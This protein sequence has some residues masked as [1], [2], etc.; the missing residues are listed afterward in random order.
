[1]NQN[2]L[3]RTSA[4]SLSLLFAIAI[5]ACDDHYSTQ[6][7][8]A[9]CEDLTS[10]NPATNPPE[11]FLDCVACHESCGIDCQQRGSSPEDYVCPSEL[12]EAAGGG[13]EGGAGG[14][15]E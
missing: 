12:D 11:T 15:A 4:A 8:Y 9:L 6:D 7:A 1:M 14:A 5:A 3:R 2:Q 10:Q 13:G